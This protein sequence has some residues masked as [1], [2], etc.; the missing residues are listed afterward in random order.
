VS[1][2]IHISDDGHI[3]ATH[4]SGRALWSCRI[5]GADREWVNSIELA[6]GLYH[7]FLYAYDADEGDS[8]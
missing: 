3:E 6:E 5:D 4:N 1:V 7:S 2:D 8:K